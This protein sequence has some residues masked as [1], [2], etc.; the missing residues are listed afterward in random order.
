MTSVRSAF[1]ALLLEVALAIG[2]DRRERPRPPDPPQTLASAARPA[3]SS[4]PSAAFP[5]AMAAIAAST[6]TPAFAPV[7]RHSSSP[8]ASS[9]RPA[10]GCRVVRGPIGLPRRVPASLAVRGDALLAIMD[11]DG[12]PRTLSIAAGARGAAQ[13]TPPAETVDESCCAGP[14]V[15]CALTSN[16]VFC[17]DRSGLI[18]RSSLLGGDNHVVASA[19]SGSRIAATE[20]G[21][22]HVALG[23]VASRKTTEGWVSEAW[24]EIDDGAPQRISE[25]GSGATSVSLIARSPGLLAV[26]V[27]ARSALTAVHARTI[28]YESGH[29]NLG[30]DAVVFVGSPSDRRTVAS[31]IGVPG[32]PVWSL[33]PIARDVASFGLALA[34][35]HEPPRIDEPVVWSL[36]PNGLDAPPVAVAESSGRIWAARVRPNSAEPGAPEILELGEVTEERAFD[37]RDVRP[38]AGHVTHVAL[39]SDATG[40]LWLSWVDASGSSLLRLACG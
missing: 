7:A 25:D 9:S 27:D 30:E 18:H 6:P 4:G 13:R 29:A 19:R 26:M 17:A 24:L 39:A 37:G 33:L 16:L 38:V 14:S 1:I 40:A 34:R 3:A 35:I 5:S 31:V 36:Y 22:G 10:P 2:C 15:P 28:S 12:R 8:P 20:L 21:Q 23:Y 32:G 11:D